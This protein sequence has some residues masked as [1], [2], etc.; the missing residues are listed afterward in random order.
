M[1]AGPFTDKAVAALTSTVEG[2]T[3]TVTLVR[4]GRSASI[5]TRALTVADLLLEE[6]IVRSADDALDVDADSALAD[7]ETITYHAA[8]PVTLVVD[9][10]SQTV[11][12]TADTVGALLAQQNIAYDAHDTVTPAAT[13]AVSDGETVEV[14]HVSSW[15]EHRRVSV[16]PPVRHVVSFAL[17][18][19]TTRVVNPGLPG[20]RETSYLVERASTRSAPPI[21]TI[22]ASR[23]IRPTR[24]RIIAAG[25][26][27]YQAFASLAARGFE[28]TLRLAKSALAMVATAYTPYCAGCS[29]HGLTAIGVPAGHGVVAVDPRVIPL[30]SHLYI[31]GYGAAVAGD[32]GGAIQGNRIDLGFINE[33]DAREFGRR[34]ITVYVL[35][36]GP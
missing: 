21:R 24:P 28:G 8:V 32:T 11:R 36:P 15:I 23:V 12:S 20:I 22:I 35:S 30:G 16:A 18:L 10:V 13:T 19:G 2:P 33:A 6:H 1:S 7:G 9:G 5:Q 34:N 17:A 25:I 4:D 14:D 3:K 27:E 29:G 26:G 31:P